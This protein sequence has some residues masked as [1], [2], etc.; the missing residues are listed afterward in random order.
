MK[1]AKYQLSIA[2]FMLFAL[3]LYSLGPAMAEG[4][5]EFWNAS[6]RHISGDINADGQKD[7]Q[8][9]LLL[10]RY[11]AGNDVSIDTLAADVNGDGLVDGCDI[12]RIARYLA[13]QGAVFSRP[14]IESTQYV[15]NTNTY[16]FHYPGCKSVNQ[17]K[18]E[19]YKLYYGDRQEIIQM[20]Y[21]PCGI[22][23]P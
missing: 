8:D 14:K 7:D 22:C 23:K 21:S 10:A 19:N 11:V 17:I 13:G 5:N 18:D 6:G 9:I 4:R 12:L 3:C 15:L 2:V 1:K 16:K 20:E